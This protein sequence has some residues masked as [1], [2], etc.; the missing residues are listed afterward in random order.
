MSASYPP[1]SLLFD[2]LD[3]IIDLLK[4]QL[5]AAVSPA[6]IERYPDLRDVQ[7]GVSRTNRILEYLLV[8][9]LPSGPEQVIPVTV[10]VVP[11]PLAVNESQPLMRV[12]VTN[13]DVAQPL[14]VS[15]QGVTLLTGQIILARATATF[16]LP[17]GGELWGLVALANI[18]VSVGV[19]YDMQPILEAL[20]GPK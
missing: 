13:L 12:T 5:G 1:A 11:E 4:A 8:A 9:A 15:K 16:V 18:N 3:T 6:L 19:G 7:G 20:L 14:L 17:P 2:K 10:G